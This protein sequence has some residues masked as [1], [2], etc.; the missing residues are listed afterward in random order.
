M[1]K[2]SYIF[3]GNKTHCT[4][5]G[6]CVQVCSQHA[7]SMNPDKEGFLYPTL[8]VERCIECGLC[9]KTCPVVNNNRANIFDNQRGYVATTN[10][11]HYYKES[12][13]IGI[14]TMLSEAV[15]KDGGI[16][17]GSFLDETDW[18][19]YH[20]GVYDL[21]GVE[22]IRNSKYLQSDTKGT[23]SEVKDSLKNNKTVLY[24]GTPCQIAGLKAYLNRDYPNLYMVDIICHGVFSP[25]L[26]PLEV[27]Y[28]EKKY[29]TKIANFRF[30][31]KRKYKNANGGM[32]N[33][34]ILL[35]NGKTK[36][37]ERH[38]S[39]SPSYRAYAY[40]GD[41]NN[42]NLRLSCYECSFRD[43]ERFGDLTIGDPWFINGAHIKNKK[44]KSSNSVRSI[45]TINTRKGEIMVEKIHALIESQEL[46][47][48][49]MFR[50]PALLKQNR[51]V[52]EIREQ[53][54]KRIEEEDYSC[55]IEDLLHCNLDKAHELFV[56]NYIKSL[57]KR[58]IKS[59]LHL[60]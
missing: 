53:L 55:V 11:E 9:D 7:L 59:I 35:P 58:I 13:T 15:I 60:Q 31:S 39:S 45:F 25:K 56:K 42:Y 47:I 16:V 32:V 52:D 4:G 12:A 19:A 21:T 26:M 22:S 36:H 27:H 23:F 43:K 20:I 8:D 41:G 2:K 33:F 6:A 5:C 48:D 50:Q 10:N 28:W 3:N 49:D 57:I 51:Q 18:K 24:I 40:S 46:S 1:E 37:I 29:N 17:F 14:C 54:Y 44:L 34:D 30:R 38:A